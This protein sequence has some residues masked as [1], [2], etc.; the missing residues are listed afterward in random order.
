MDNFQ[1][2]NEEDTLVNAIVSDVEE[3][4]ISRATT[5]RRKSSYVGLVPL[6]GIMDL[7]VG[8]ELY[9]PEGQRG[10]I[11]G[12]TAAGLIIFDLRSNGGRDYVCVEAHPGSFAGWNTSGGVVL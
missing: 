5:R 7:P 12:H 10:Y 9:G 1:S 2:W 11:A 6:K 3:P 4:A 8:T